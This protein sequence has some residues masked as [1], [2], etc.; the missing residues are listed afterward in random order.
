MAARTRVCA[1]TI[2]CALTIPPLQLPLLMAAMTPEQQMRAEAN[3]QKAL[4]IRAASPLFCLCLSDQ[5]AHHH[6]C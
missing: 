4:A 5:L 3:R 1:V 6:P 2:T